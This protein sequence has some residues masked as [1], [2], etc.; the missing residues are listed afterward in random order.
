MLWATDDPLG[1]AVFYRD[2]G[3]G[4]YTR[5]SKCL[6][7]MHI[8]TTLSILKPNKTERVMSEVGKWWGWIR[9]GMRAGSKPEVLVVYFHKHIS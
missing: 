1:E 8:Q 2:S 4:N 9:K 3:L 6:P 7:P 5:S